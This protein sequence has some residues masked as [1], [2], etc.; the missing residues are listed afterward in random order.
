VT[1]PSQTAQDLELQAADAALEPDWS[2]AD[3]PAEELEALAGKAQLISIPPPPAGVEAVRE[4][5]IARGEPGV[6][7]PNAAASGPTR[8]R[9]TRFDAELDTAELDDRERPG[10]TWS[11]RARNISRSTLTF[12][13]RRMC[14]AGRRIVV[15]VHLIDDRPTPLFGVVRNCEYE[16]EGLYRTELTLAPVPDRSSIQTWIANHHRN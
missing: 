5:L 8:G 10:P 16:S 9:A 2:E 6:A 14:Y 3:A 15:A 7:A 12:V 11:A 1:P 13:S 4:E